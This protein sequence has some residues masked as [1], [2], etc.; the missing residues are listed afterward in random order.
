MVTRS[1]IPTKE[2]GQRAGSHLDSQLEDKKGS[3][4]VLNKT[5]YGEFMAALLRSKHCIFSN[6]FSS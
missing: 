6:F 4:Y 2:T 1:T 3:L 5:A